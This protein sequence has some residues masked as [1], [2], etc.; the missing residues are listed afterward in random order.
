M[1]HDKELVY[2]HIIYSLIFFLMMYTKM[3]YYA[4]MYVFYILI[5]VYMPLHLKQYMFRFGQR[6]KQYMFRFSE[7]TALEALHVPL[8]RETPIE[9]TCLLPNSYSNEMEIRQLL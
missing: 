9:A 2:L 1:M 8:Q 4:E 6:L 7:W 3:L 5:H